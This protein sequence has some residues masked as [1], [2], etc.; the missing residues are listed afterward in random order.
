M[1]L[2]SS[3]PLIALALLLAPAPV[4][5]QPSGDP[6]ATA[7]AADR[8]ADQLQR[9][10][11]AARATAEASRLQATRQV[12]QALATA[13]AQAVT[14]TAAGATAEAQAT[15]WALEIQVTERALQAQSTR[16]ALAAENTRQAQAQRATSDAVQAQRDQLGAELDRADLEQ[17][18]AVQRLLQVGAWAALAGGI[19]TGVTVLRR[20][21]VEQPAP[22]N[23]DVIE[24]EFIEH[25]VGPV[26][27]QVLLP[28]RAQNGRVRL[29]V[30]ARDVEFVEDVR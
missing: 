28:A 17:R 21:R 7:Q 8:A 15:L 14:A 3:F 11:Q 1:K 20:Y 2:C 10:A 13:Q 23:D 29:R 18:R 9:Q 12:E 6:I 30:A 16:S 22:V 24:G 27:G 25:A 5:A 26:P 4:Q 19:V